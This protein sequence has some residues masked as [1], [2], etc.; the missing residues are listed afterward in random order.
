MDGC[1]KDKRKET[2]KKTEHK[3]MGNMNSVRKMINM[4]PVLVESG[5]V[6]HTFQLFT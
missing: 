3:C 2:I 1:D 4:K 5:N 6:C